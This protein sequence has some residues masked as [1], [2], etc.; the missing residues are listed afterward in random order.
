MTNLVS[1]DRTR[2]VSYA[3][4]SPC[5][6]GQ[7]KATLIHNREALLNPAGALIKIKRAVL[8]QG[9]DMNV[10]DFSKAKSGTSQLENE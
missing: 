2:S 6:E 3:A 7:I 8:H 4:L 5:A 10:T 9:E 1:S